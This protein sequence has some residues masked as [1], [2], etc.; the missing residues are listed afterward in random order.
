MCF[1]KKEKKENQEPAITRRF[2]NQEA[3]ASM[4]R[5]RHC[6]QARDETPQQR[7]RQALTKD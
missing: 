6:L 1:D 5:G 4:P 2:P 7:S 3:N